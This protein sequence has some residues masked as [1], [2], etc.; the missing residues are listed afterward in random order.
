MRRMRINN[1]EIRIVVS[2]CR[3]QKLKLKK[4]GGLLRSL[5]N[6]SFVHFSQTSIV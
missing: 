3:P 6:S 2:S 5:Q 1:L 4:A